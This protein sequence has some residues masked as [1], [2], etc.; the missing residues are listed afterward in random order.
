MH[1]EV[2]DKKFKYSE[3]TFLWTIQAPISG[4][5]II[6]IE[7]LDLKIESPNVCI[8]LFFNLINYLFFFP[9][10]PHAHYVFDKLLQ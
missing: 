10:P 1:A 4:K 9:I 3:T 6:D 7:F 5:F 8:V 2:I